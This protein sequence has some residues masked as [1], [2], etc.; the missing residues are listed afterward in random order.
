[1]SVDR[2]NEDFYRRKHGRA[3]GSEKTSRRLLLTFIL[4]KAKGGAEI[5]A[6]SVDHL[7]RYIELSFKPAKRRGKEIS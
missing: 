5:A 3:G 4:V 7:H 2:W 6:A 1:V